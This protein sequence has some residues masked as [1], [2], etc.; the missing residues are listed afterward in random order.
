MAFGFV[1]VKFALFVKQ[2]SFIL[3]E[4]Q[5]SVALPSRGY[6]AILGIVLVA[7][8]T[9]MALLAFF[10]YKNIE[11][12]LNTNTFYPSSSLSLMF[13]IAI[14]LAGLLLVTYLIPSI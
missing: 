4:G 6:S 1:V 3:D 5:K 10:R 7:L 2:I 8:G 14:I 9:L 11:R 13:T 12:Q